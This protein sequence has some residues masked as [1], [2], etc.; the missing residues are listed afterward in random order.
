M[1]IKSQP[2]ARAV[3]G[4]SCHDADISQRA[5][6]AE[7]LTTETKRCQFLTKPI[8]ER[9]RTRCITIEQA[10]RQQPLTSRSAK[11]EIFDV[12]YFNVRAV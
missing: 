12:W 9:L 4:G 7:R 10:Y 6:G 5:Q 3:L 11:S 1:M 8:N 2:C